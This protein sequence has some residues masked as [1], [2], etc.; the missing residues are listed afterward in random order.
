MVTD[1]HLDR[2]KNKFILQATLNYFKSTN[3]GSGSIF[4]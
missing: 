4:D 3:R 1:S 2:N